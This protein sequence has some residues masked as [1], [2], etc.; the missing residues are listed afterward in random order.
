[1]LALAASHGWDPDG[2][3]RPGHPV[4][5]RM[6]REIARWSGVAE[7]E[8]GTAVDGCGVPCFSVPLRAMAASFARF[9]AATARGEA[10]ARIV[11]AMTGHPFMVGGTGRACT[12]VMERAR[13]RVF[14]KVG[15][16]GV[17]GAGVPE[18]GLGV[19]IKVA[20]GARRAAEVALIRVLRLVGALD[21]ADVQSLTGWARPD[22]RNTR[23]D[24]VG[25][26]QATFGLSW[27]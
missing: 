9:A 7:R 27:T 12:A 24:V 13:G 6:L 20:D 11:A 10:P 22:V 14:V 23:G 1:M 4:Q 21:D 2:Y 17:Y 16:E 19:A 15:A 3:H 18:R 8:V 26:I 5:A 25:R